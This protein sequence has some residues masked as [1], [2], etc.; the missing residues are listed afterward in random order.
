VRHLT[1]REPRVHETTRPVTTRRRVGHTTT[2]IHYPPQID[3]R[4]TRGISYSDEWQ[5]WSQQ[6]VKFFSVEWTKLRDDVT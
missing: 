1:P 3:D 5:L 6:L 4:P 2:R